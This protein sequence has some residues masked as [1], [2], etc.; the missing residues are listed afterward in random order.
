MRRRWWIIAIIL[1]AIV[2][3]GSAALIRFRPRP[4]RPL[5][6]VV[7]L[8]LARISDEPVKYLPEP[9]GL[10]VAE[11][12]DIFFS[13]SN[14]GRIY[15][16]PA[17]GYSRRALSR[18]NIVVAE[19]FETPS[20]IALER[21]GNLIVA[22]T[23]AHTIARIDFKVNKWRVI[24]GKDGVSGF[25]DGPGKEARFNGPVGL[26]LDQDGTIFVADTYN[27]RIR[28]I[29]PA[30]VVRTL[31][32]GGEPGFRDGT[33]EEA[34]FDTPCG[35]AIARDGGLLIADTGNHRIRRVG[36]D[37][38]VSTLAGT[39]AAAIVDGEPG[40]AGFYQPLAIAVLAA[41]RYY[42]ADAGTIRLCTL[43]EQESVRTI[44]SGYPFGMVD[45][46]LAKARINSPAGLA[47][48]P[49][50]EL[51]FADGG[52]GLVRAIVPA[53]SRIGLRAEAN[54]V[55][56]RPEQMREQL[57][58]RWPFAPPEA[59]RDIAGTFGEIRGERLP[60]HETHFHTG[61]DI[62]G[63]Y[64][65]TVCAIFSERVTRPLAAED[66]GE[67]RERLRLP[68]FQYIHLRLGRDRNDQPLGNFA[69][70]AISFQR[71][72]DNRVVGVRL[73]RGTRINA[74]D[75]IGTLN[76]LNHVHLVAGPPAYEINA[77]SLLRLPG[78]GDTM[79]PV[80]EDVTILNERGEPVSEP[81]KVAEVSG[82]LRLTA[83]VYDRIDGNPRY[84]RLGIYRL[85]YQ[86]LGAGG[87]PAPG[88]EEPRYNLVF[89]RLCD[90]PGVV[91]L[92]FAEGSQSSYNGM[93]VFN[94]FVT[95][96][97]RGG[98]G[99]E[100]FWDAAKLAAG[101]YTLRV[102]AEDHFGNQSRRDVFVRVVK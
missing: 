47:L 53:D 92:A 84:R 28:A 63:A 86:V 2:A 55:V 40:A 18:E 72:E 9:F 3:A 81:G 29:S 96:V 6:A 68:F 87:G 21:D 88:F 42:V 79:P 98:E 59:R 80:I 34:R 65:E 20:A 48:L 17:A 15:R 10:A 73:R 76:Q 1:A 50:G 67:L 43:G 19:G 25:A 30:G 60:D 24:A 71:G 39:G 22:N 77:L 82:R 13:E 5:A 75:P 95:N 27:D 94:Y 14:S 49:G 23:G 97:V 54:S 89:D 64:G 83:R 11:Q 62:P 31:A 74:G 44:A 51:V 78:L 69:P 4:P 46:E 7:T 85:G 12:G 91:F 57:E 56:I 16:V 32:G 99:R 35:I 37:G 58:P 93:T 33:G 41:D 66:A 38:R 61:L 26:A 45:G 102:I 100:D 70:G 90:D 8:A 36:R 101:D 52:N